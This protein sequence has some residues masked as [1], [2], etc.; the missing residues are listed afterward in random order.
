MVPSSSRAALALGCYRG[1]SNSN[2]NGSG[3]G[4]GGDQ[5][6]SGTPATVVWLRLHDPRCRGLS[7]MGPNEEPLDW[8]VALPVFAVRESRMCMPEAGTLG[9]TPGMVLHPVT[10]RYALVD[11]GAGACTVCQWFVR[12]FV[13]SLDG[14][15]NGWV[16]C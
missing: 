9:Y 6:G 1:G 16:D 7:V 15:M 10:Q 3:S 5:T 13:R 8:V 4:S 12:S 11:A 2:S 14:S